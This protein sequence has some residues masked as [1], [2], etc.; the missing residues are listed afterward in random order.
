MIRMNDG[1]QL[2]CTMVQVIM[3]CFFVRFK[4]FSVTVFYLIF[5]QFDLIS[6]LLRDSITPK[7]DL[8]YQ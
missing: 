1:Y 5:F 2:A 3:M 8:E 4:S 7:N 6:H